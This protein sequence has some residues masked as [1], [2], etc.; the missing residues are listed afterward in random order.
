MKNFLK[1]IALLL[2]ISSCNY[3][4]VEYSEEKILQTGEKLIRG[5][6]NSD[7]GYIIVGHGLIQKIS[8]L[9]LNS[10]NSIL[11]VRQGD[12]AKPYGDGKATAILI[13]KNKKDSIAIRIRLNSINKNHYIIGWMTLK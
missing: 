5:E 1:I 8:D 7:S 4:Q 13:I 10:E 11:K 2:I 6:Y 9:K 12:L 3:K